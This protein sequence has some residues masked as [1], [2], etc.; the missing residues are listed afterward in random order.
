[1]RMN[2]H[3]QGFELRLHELRA[4]FGSFQLAFAETV[5]ITECVTHSEDEPVDEHPFIEVDI[6]EIEDSAP[7]KTARPSYDEH[8]QNDVSNEQSNG[9]KDAYA[10][11]KGSSSSPIVTFETIAPG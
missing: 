2:L 3:F 8:I 7:R 6:R 4:K 5:V 11:V 9:Q 10:E 1:M